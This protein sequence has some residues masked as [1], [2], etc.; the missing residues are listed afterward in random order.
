M[1]DD[2]LSETAAKMTPEESH[3][4]AHA[5]SDAPTQ[6]SSTQPHKALTLLDLPLDML[7]EIVKEVT[8]SLNHFNE[9]S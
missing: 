7:R 6:P 5:S 1:D 3:N 4:D 9:E 8:P 2:S